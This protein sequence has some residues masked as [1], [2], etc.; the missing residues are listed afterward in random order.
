VFQAAA[1]KA[2]CLLIPVSHVL[3]KSRGRARV[4]KHRRC[5][6]NPEGE[7]IPPLAKMFP[8]RPYESGIAAGTWN[9][10]SFDVPEVSGVS[11]AVD[12]LWTLVG[13]RNH[14]PADQP[15]RLREVLLTPVLTGTTG[16]R[17]QSWD[18]P[19]ATRRSSSVMSLP[20]TVGPRV[21]SGKSLVRLIPRRWCCHQFR[22]VKK[23]CFGSKSG[24]CRWCGRQPRKPA[25]KGLGQVA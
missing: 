7:I 16:P 1:R 9:S 17:L 4:T 22:P 5:V 19:R 8:F 20:S 2:P 15:R 10:A 21:A 3:K 18:C 25:L 6:I 14:A 13:P 23:T 12:L 24:T 11:V